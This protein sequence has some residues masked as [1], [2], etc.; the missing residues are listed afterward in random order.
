MNKRIR[1]LK[2][3]KEISP[4]PLIMLSQIQL[5]QA[6]LTYSFDAHFNIIPQPCL[7]LPGGA[8]PSF[9]PKTRYF[10]HPLRATCLALLILLDFIT[11]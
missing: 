3:V 4:P 1:A 10:L 11:Q 9:P 5:V 2:L 8:F 7:S 6:L